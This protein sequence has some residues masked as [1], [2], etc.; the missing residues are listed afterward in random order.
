MGCGM[1]VRQFLKLPD[2]LQA[3]AHKAYLTLM[4]PANLA[5]L[6]DPEPADTRAIPRA[7]T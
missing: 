4:W 2:R 3:E 5:P 1:T 7:A 6:A